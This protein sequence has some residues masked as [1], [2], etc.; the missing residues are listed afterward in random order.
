[1]LKFEKT[2]FKLYF[3]KLKEIFYKVKVVKKYFNKIYLEKIGKFWGRLKFFTVE[4]SFF[5]K[6]LVV[7]KFVKRFLIC[8]VIGL[9][10]SKLF[11]KKL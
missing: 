4:F 3:K 7:I 8:L 10:F 6:I 5:V 11:I 2:L 9:K 1:M